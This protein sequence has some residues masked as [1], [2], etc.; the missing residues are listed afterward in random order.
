MG[1]ISFPSEIHVKLWGLELHFLSL[2]RCGINYDTIWYT[3]MHDKNTDN[4]I[5][6]K[7]T[8]GTLPRKWQN[9]ERYIL[10]H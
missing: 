5:D 2:F 1:N 6:M 10:S 8:T 9:H 4:K 3:I 7:H